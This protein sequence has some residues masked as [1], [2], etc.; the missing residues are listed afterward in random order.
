[1]EKN[2]IISYENL[3]DDMVKIDATVKKETKYIAG[4]VLVLSVIMQAIFLIADQWNYTVL[5]GN[6]ISG[7][8][9][10]FNFFLMGITVQKALQKEAKEAK[11]AMKVSQLYRTLFLAVVL[12]LGFTLPCFDMWATVIPFFFP[13]IAI[14]FHPLFD[15]RK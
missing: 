3:G 8:A 5:L 1:M 6:L 4:F 10:I 7:L 2:W 13:R 9:G 12:I 14:A 15:K 11:A